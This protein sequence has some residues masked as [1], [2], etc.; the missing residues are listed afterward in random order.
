M[1]YHVPSAPPI[2]TTTARRYVIFGAIMLVYMFY[3]FCWNTENF[4]RPYMAE[5]LGLSKTQVAAFYTFQALGAMI[6]A[7]ILS[8]VADRTS[9]R[10]TLACISF[11][12]GL[13]ALGVYFVDSFATALV[14]RFVMGFFLG[15]VF[16]TVVSVYVGLFPATVLGFLAGVVQLAYNGGDALLSWFGRH[17][18]ASNW[19]EIL[20]IGGVGAICAG[21]VVVLVVPDDRTRIT[22]DGSVVKVARAKPAMRELFVDGR[23]KLT[24]RLALLAG[25]NY[26]AYQAFSGWATT[27]LREVHGYP[28]DMV[29][30]LMTVLHVGSMVGALLWG[31]AADRFGR[32]A[33]AIGFVFAALA[34]VAYL[35]LPATPVMLATTGFAYGFCIV[36][37]GIWGPYFAEMYP[38]HLRATAASI[39]NWGRIVSLLGSLLTGWIAEHFGLYT[40]MYIG[41]A[42]YA[43]AALLWW[44]LPETLQRKPAV[45]PVAVRKPG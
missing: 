42:T 20:Q 1:S 29:G 22:A 8:Q 24:W 39:I 41:G 19:H 37:H 30:K 7:I 17:Y 43:L 13:A 18:D 34:I 38:E 5:S 16:G 44:T 6:G 23:W 27:F 14:Q 35:T 9:R 3:A 4:L 21:I 15:G 2:E 32:R 28:T 25:L 45:I 40:I 33:N 11:G 12:I 31:M 36:S 26:F 10:N